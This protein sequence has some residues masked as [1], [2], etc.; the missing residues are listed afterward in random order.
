MPSIS[1]PPKLRHYFRVHRKVGGRGPICNQWAAAAA[2]WEICVALAKA[3]PVQSSLRMSSAFPNAGGTLEGT[4]GSCIMEWR[5]QR[6]IERTELPT[7]LAKGLRRLYGAGV[8][9][10]ESVSPRT[11]QSLSPHASFGS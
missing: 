11:I 10:A 4:L 2:A 8:R 3:Q 9:L 7:V 1:G 5:L 6:K